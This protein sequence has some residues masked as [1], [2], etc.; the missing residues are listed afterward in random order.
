MNMYVFHYIRNCRDSAP[1][2]IK[3]AKTDQLLA[4]ER[5]RRMIPVCAFSCE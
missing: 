2:A 3:R 5:G 1:K 4:V